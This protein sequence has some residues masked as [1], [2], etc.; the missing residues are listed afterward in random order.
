[1]ICDDHVTIYMLDNLIK[2]VKICTIINL[3]IKEIDMTL[4]HINLTS[5]LFKEIKAT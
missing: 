3:K 1:V 2:R 5:L 4:L